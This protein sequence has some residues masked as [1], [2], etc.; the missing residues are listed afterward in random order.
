MGE[1]HV[2]A[3]IYLENK[4]DSEE[5]RGP[6]AF[7]VRFF[8]DD[9]ETYVVIDDHFPAMGN[10]SWAFVKGGNEGHELW[11]M[12]LEKAYA[13]LNGSFNFIEAGKVQYA[14]SDMT[15][16]IPEQIDMRKIG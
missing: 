9:E 1:K 13:K 12:V 6:G 3:C 2:R 16:G 15:G 11:P 8:K 7:C 10:G 14:L 5:W 4:K